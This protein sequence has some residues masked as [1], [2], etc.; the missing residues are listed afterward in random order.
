M[1]VL[2]ILCVLDPAQQQYDAKADLLYRFYLLFT[3]I[4]VIGGFIGIAV[5]IWQ[6]TVTRRAAEAAKASA[7][8]IINSERAWIFLDIALIGNVVHAQQHEPHITRIRASYRYRNV[9][10]SP[11]WITEMIFYSEIYNS[12]SLPKKPDIG[13]LG[14]FEYGPQPFEAGGDKTCEQSW[15]VQGR[16]G[17]GNFTLVLGVIKYL[18]IFEKQRITVCGYMLSPDEKT[19]E[20]IAGHEYNQYT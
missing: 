5:L 18:D 9:G 13:S 15:D 17:S 1:H 2:L 7:D 8:S 12:G 10:K 3:V 19:L 16:P 20:R 14:P 4:G 6:T 11:A